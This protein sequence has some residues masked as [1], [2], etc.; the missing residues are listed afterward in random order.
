MSYIF[1][2]F[3]P[4]FFR[5]LVAVFFGHVGIDEREFVSYIWFGFL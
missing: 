4:S 3:K 5:K 2:R 1:G